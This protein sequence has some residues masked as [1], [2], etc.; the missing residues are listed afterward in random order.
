MLKYCCSKTKFS[1][2][3]FKLVGLIVFNKISKNFPLLQN[4]VK[5]KSGMS[6]I[7]KSTTKN[8]L[9]PADFKVRNHFFFVEKKLFQFCGYVR[10][11]SV[12]SI[13]DKK[14]TIFKLFKYENMK[15]ISSLENLDNFFR[16]NY[17]FFGI[18]IDLETL[19]YFLIKHLYNYFT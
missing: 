13:R 2:S 12:V 15:S 1:L 8:G 5:I 17:Q 19:I 7:F 10:F 4:G 16:K 6:P 3:F 9:T 14:K 18:S 11:V